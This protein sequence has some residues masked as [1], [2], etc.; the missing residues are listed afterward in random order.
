MVGRVVETRKR[1]DLLVSLRG[2]PKF[3]VAP[4]GWG[5]GRQWRTQRGP[6]AEVKTFLAP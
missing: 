3:E 5:Y 1:R 4:L 2:G 6:R